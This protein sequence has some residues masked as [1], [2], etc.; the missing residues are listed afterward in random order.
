[1]TRPWLGIVADDV[2]GACDVAG[3]LSELGVGTAIILGRPDGTLDNDPD[4]VVVGLSTRSVDAALAVSESLAAARWLRRQG[5]TQLYQKYCS[6]FDSTERGNI[7]PVADAM[8]DLVGSGISV[9]TPATPTAGRTQRSG[10]LFVNEL[11]LAESAMREHPVNPMTESSVVRLLERQSN[12]SVELVHL[13]AFPRADARLAGDGTP[14]HILVDAVDDG[15]LDLTAAAIAKSPVAVLAGGGAGLAL[16]MARGR[17]GRSTIRS[18]EAVSDGG[19]LILCGSGSER[20]REQIAR[21]D[22]EVVVLDPVAIAADEEAAILRITE[23]LGVKPGPVLVATPN[24]PDE[25]R[26]AQRA[27]GIEAAA[28]LVGRT[29]GAIAVAAVETLGIRRIVVA[30]GETS[31]AVVAALGIRRLDISALA[32]TGVPWTVGVRADGTAIALL[33]KSGNF[34]GPDLFDTAWEVAP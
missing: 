34:G 27:L 11:P 2:T 10:I 22:G 16:A 25:V 6:T 32:A 29:L 7:G 28:A 12:R 4:C 24:S 5:V 19:R 30:G 18:G 14:R 1:M 20:T 8:A 13:D 23:Q 26:A 15:D 33:L 21:F 3:G 31:G 9:G 17:G